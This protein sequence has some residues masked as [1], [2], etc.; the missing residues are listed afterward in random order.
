MD[1]CQVCGLAVEAERREEALV[2]K[3]RNPHCVRF[4]LVM[5]ETVAPKENAASMDRASAQV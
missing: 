4:G 5:R 3:C 2:W 1:F